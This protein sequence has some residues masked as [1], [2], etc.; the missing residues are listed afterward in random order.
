VGETTKHFS[1]LRLA[2][3]TIRGICLLDRDRGDVPEGRD[4]PTPSAGHRGPSRSGTYTC[5]RP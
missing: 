1:C 4:F 2:E 3:P 5:L